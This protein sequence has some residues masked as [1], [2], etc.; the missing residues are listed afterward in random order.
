[1]RIVTMA[2]GNQTIRHP[3]ARLHRSDSAPQILL[4]RVHLCD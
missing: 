3:R 4:T 2:C 1:M